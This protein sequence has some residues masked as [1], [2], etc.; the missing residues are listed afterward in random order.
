ML[1]RLQEKMTQERKKQCVQPLAGLS[2]NGHSSQYCSRRN[3]QTRVISGWKVVQGAESETG[4]FGTY[5]GAKHTF[6]AP[7]MA[8]HLD[9]KAKSWLPDTK[10]SLS[11]LVG[12][13][14]YAMP[15]P[16]DN[17]LR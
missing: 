6:L 1:N 3:N 9:L 4:Q 15:N 2:L 14:T 13:Y 5:R 12:I 10:N 7:W 16:H 17:P 11:F 8:W